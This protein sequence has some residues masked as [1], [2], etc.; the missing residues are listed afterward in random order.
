M[1]AQH[2]HQHR[3]STKIS[4]DFFLHH[5]FI[6]GPK[7]PSQS[8]QKFTFYLYLWWR[9]RE[10]GK[11]RWSQRKPSEQPQR[12]WWKWAAAGMGAQGL[13]GADAES[14]ASFRGTSLETT[15]L[16][17]SHLAR[18][19][20]V[21]EKGFLF[22]NYA[23]GFAP[24]FYQNQTK[25]Y[26]TTLHKVNDRTWLVLFPETWHSSGTLTVLKELDAS[27]KSHPWSHIE[28]PQIL[29]YHWHIYSLVSV[30]SIRRFISKASAK[31]EVPWHR[32]WEPPRFGQSRPEPHLT[33]GNW[34]HGP[35]REKKKRLKIRRE[36]KL[37]PLWF[38]NV[39]KIYAV[40][41]SILCWSQWIFKFTINQQLFF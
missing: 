1:P 20:M 10:D 21:P 31:P 13:G 35:R 27:A 25:C 34:W 4:S 7:D 26:S 8:L 3:T 38:Q 5:N 17:L 22:W 40:K 19:Y 30:N 2:R 29:I 14:S 36:V 37:L 12:W 23:Y 15:S 28:V 24:L 41:K 9:K 33:A 11:W 32:A 18:I 16:L 6:E 39:A